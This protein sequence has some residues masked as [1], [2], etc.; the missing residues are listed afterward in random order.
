MLDENSVTGEI[1]VNDGRITQVQIAE[2]RENLR[3]PP[4]PRLQGELLKVAFG[5]SEKLLEGTTAHVFSDENDSRLVIVR[6]RPITVELN[7]VGV[8]QLCETVKH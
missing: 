5:T 1:S 3:A 7:N 8:L 6:V 4:F 2:G